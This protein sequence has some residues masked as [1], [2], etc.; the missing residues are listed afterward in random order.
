MIT[1]IHIRRML[2]VL[3]AFAAT[4]GPLLKQMMP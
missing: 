2:I 4:T 3:F 1:D